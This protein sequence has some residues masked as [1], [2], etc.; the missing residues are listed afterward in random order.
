LKR[1]RKR[2]K[3]LHGEST[4]SN[5]QSSKEKKNARKIFYKKETEVT[6]AVSSLDYKKNKIIGILRIETLFSR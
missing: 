6:Y 4:I 3:I 5:S 2:G 1:K